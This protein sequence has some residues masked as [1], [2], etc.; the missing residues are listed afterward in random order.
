MSEVVKTEWDEIIEHVL[1][2]QRCEIRIDTTLFVFIHYLLK[3]FVNA[4]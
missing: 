1:E 2:E 3:L 4:L